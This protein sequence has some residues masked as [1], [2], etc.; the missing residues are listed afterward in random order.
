VDEHER[1]VPDVERTW[2]DARSEFMAAHVARQ[3]EFAAWDG[4]GAALV[5]WAV[6]RNLKAGGLPAQE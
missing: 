3:A 4:S 2:H 1:L 6:A 5:D